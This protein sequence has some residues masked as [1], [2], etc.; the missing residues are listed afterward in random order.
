MATQS[1]LTYSVDLVLCIDATGSMT[2]L[3]DTVKEKALNFNTDLRSAME[4]K[5]KAIDTLRVR[6]VAFRDFTDGEAP[7]LEE[8]DFF[9]LGEE[10]EEFA[11][12]LQ[13]V[14]ARGGGDEPESGLEALAVAMRSSWQTVG[15]KK[16][17]VIALW[18]DATPHELGA[19]LGGGL[20]QP[21]ADLPRTFD[22]LTDM[23]EGQAGVMNQQAKR[24]IV[25]APDAPGWNE[26]GNHWTQSLQY[27][28]RAGEGLNEI[29]YNAILSTIA[30]SV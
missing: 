18:T 17:H 13:G 28:S 11:S 15:D 27:V 8:S 1:G 24:L 14:E 10:A 23:W 22:E 19:P 25:Y 3:I 7:P 2:G 4:A 30:E 29:D 6:V 21:P 12:F 5:G 16:R 26:I 20:P 9:V